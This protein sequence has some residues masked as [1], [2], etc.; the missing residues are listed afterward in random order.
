MNNADYAARKARPML[1]RMLRDGSK[2]QIVA[3]PTRGI[4]ADQITDNTIYVKN[5]DA[6]SSTLDG[7]KDIIL[8]PNDLIKRV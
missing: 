8:Y 1:F 6:F 7:S 4:R 5:S 2:F 3:E